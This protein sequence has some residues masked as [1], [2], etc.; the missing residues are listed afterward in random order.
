M[1]RKLLTTTLLSISILSLNLSAG[2]QMKC[3]N[4]VCMVDLSTIT[5]KAKITVV[6]KKTVSINDY[7]TVIIDNIETIVLSPLKYVMS[8]DEIAEY[9]LEQMQKNLL[10]PSLSS[11]GLALSNDFCE[12][13]LKAVA[14]VGVENTYECT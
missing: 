1:N 2:T 11:E 13:N 5:P 7:R 9:D 14:V 8:Q 10:I 4:G 3:S 12:D 6:E